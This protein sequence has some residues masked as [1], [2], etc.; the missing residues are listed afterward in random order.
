MRRMDRRALFLAVCLAIAG[1]LYAQSG[2]TTYEYDNL[3][4][5][6]RMV[7]PAG[8]TTYTY[9]AVGNRTTKQFTPSVAKPS[10]APALQAVPVSADSAATVRR[11]ASSTPIVTAAKGT[12]A[13]KEQDVKPQNP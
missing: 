4:R 9:D 6:V 2:K 7:S 1:G 8:V 3:N 13:A 10:Q 11:Q 12:L 5:L